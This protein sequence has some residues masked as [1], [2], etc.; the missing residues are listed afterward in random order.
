MVKTSTHK[1]ARVLVVDDHGLFLN[2]VSGILRQHPHVVIIGEVQDGVMAVQQAEALRPDII[3]LDIGLP[4]LNGID[5]AHQIRSTVPQARIVFLTSESS[6]DV[7]Q[8]ALNLGAWGYVE[9]ICAG[10]EL[11]SAITTVLNGERFLSSGVRE[12]HLA[13]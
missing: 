8:E 9:K 1:Q 12:Y 6:P 13:G 10:Q 4:K 3:L 5:A 2:F 7:V 11:L